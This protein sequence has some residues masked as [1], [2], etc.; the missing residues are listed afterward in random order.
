MRFIKWL[1]EFR[2]VIL[3]VVLVGGFVVT[4]WSAWEALQAEL[5]DLRKDVNCVRDDVGALRTGVILLIDKQEETVPLHASG[6]PLAGDL[7]TQIQIARCKVI[8]RDIHPTQLRCMALNSYEDSE[9]LLGLVGAAAQ[10]RACQERY[11]VEPEPLR[12][13]SQAADTP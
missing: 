1:K 7:R 12:Q 3:T 8:N 5:L 4:G 11:A 6:K 9:V 10:R 13:K 2:V